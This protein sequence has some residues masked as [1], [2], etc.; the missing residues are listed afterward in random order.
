M[1]VFSTAFPAFAKKTSKN[2]GGLFFADPGHDG[3]LN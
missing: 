3:S 2:F 1:Q